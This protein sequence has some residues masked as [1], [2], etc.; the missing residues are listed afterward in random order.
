MAIDPTFQRWAVRF[1]QGADV[2]LIEL[3]TD[4]GA[5]FWV[6]AVSDLDGEKIGVEAA[7]LDDNDMIW[8]NTGLAYVDGEFRQGGDA[9][10]AFDLDETVSGV[11]L[12]LRS[13]DEESPDPAQR[14]APSL[15]CRWHE[16]LRQAIE[17]DFTG[18]CELC[19]GCGHWFF[20]PPRAMTL[21]EITLDLEGRGHSE[22]TD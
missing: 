1:A 13:G 12:N 7:K 9:R 3:E 8:V 5:R 21:S 17:A 6:L 16:Y 15:Q 22:P 14:R 20:A 18:D 2:E 11:T 4:S 19:G 10:S